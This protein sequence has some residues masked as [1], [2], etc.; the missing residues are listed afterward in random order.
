MNEKEIIK[1]I[2][3]IRKEIKYSTVD[4]PVE[5]IISNLKNGRFF[6][7]SYQRE[8]VWNNQKKSMF[9]ESILMGLPIPFLFLYREKDKG[10]LEIVDGAQRI[11]TLSAYYDN[12]IILNN[13]DKLVSLNGTK[14]E[15]LPKKYQETFL[16]T[17]LRMI[18]LDE[19]TT[20]D[21]RREIFKRLNTTSEKLKSSEI[22]K[23]SL[24]GDFSNFISKCA[25]NP[26]F[27]EMC[28][29]T[30]SKTRRKEEEELV[31]RFFAYSESLKNYNGK[32]NDF[33]YNYVENK[34]SGKFNKDIM[35]NEFIETF[36][37]LKLNNITLAK[38]GRK[39][40]SRTRFE[41]I[42]VGTN[43]ALKEKPKL[44]NIKLNLKEL[45]SEEFEK[46]TSSDAANNR[47]KLERRINFVRELILSKD[48][49]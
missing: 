33:I 37:F 20:I 3:D 12:N 42:T 36:K 8:Y 22:R 9:I 47:S 11:Q 10:Y 31:S 4:Y 27:I 13:L 21:S 2:Q 35:H 15:H 45:D 46:I 17:A 44:K 39:S 1:N 32:V 6:I 29:V 14:F 24:E 16:T 28:K 40:I 25:E 30:K 49:K 5:S 48:E 7:P 43:L 19:E 34:N 23:G 18:I 38:K 26:I 41:A